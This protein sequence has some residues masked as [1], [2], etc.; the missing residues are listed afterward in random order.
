M[1]RPRSALSKLTLR[2]QYFLL[3]TSMLDN[4]DLRLPT[5]QESC[6]SMQ[7]FLRLGLLQVHKGKL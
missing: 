4:I 5:F 6:P 3:D 1:C 7:T 2:Q